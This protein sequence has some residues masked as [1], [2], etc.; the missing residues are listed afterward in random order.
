MSC[1][2]RASGAAFDVEAFLRGSSWAACQV[3]YKGEPKT[4]SLPE[5]INARSGFNLVV[6]EAEFRAI[7]SQ[8]EDAIAFLKDRFEEVQRLSDFAGIE[9]VALDFAIETRDV[10]I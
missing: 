9:S 6:S 10:A 1:V 4:V 5:R 8:I 3:F 2:L 7:S